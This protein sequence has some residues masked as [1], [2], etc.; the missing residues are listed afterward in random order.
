MCVVGSATPSLESLY[1][2]EVGK[3]KVSKLTRRVDDRQLPTVH[4]V[5]LRRESPKAGKGD[6]HKESLPLD[7]QAA[8]LQSHL[9]TSES[10]VRRLRTLVACLCQEGWQVET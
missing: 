1:N 10:L 3:Y 4:V 2:V 5:D 6:T 7:Q 8:L 9:A